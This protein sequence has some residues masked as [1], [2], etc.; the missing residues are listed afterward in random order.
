MAILSTETGYRVKPS[1]TLETGP[2]SS[3]TGEVARR[4]VEAGADGLVLF[5][6]FYQ[7]NFDL[8]ALEVT[9]DLELSRA[10]V[11]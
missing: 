1:P 11:L 9:S 4:L 7:P 5:N 3:S 6:R 2:F 8:D 10:S